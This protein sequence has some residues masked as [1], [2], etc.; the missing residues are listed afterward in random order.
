[1]ADLARKPLVF[2]IDMSSRPDGYDMDSSDCVIHIVNDT[3]ISDAESKR[4]TSAELLCSMRSGVA[5]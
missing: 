3:I 1:M 2:A 4:L 5:L